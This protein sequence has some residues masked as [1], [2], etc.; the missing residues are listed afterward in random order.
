MWVQPLGWEDPLEEDMATYSSIF[1]FLFQTTISRMDKQRSTVSCEG[2][3]GGSVFKQNP[4]EM[5]ASQETRGSI[6]GSG[7]SSGEGMAMHS[8]VL[9]WRIPW[10]EETAGLQSRG[11]Q[12]ASEDIHTRGVAWG[13]V[14]DIL[15]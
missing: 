9:A 7:R 3:R 13:A 14:S 4:P 15:W 12:K 8:S 11:S 2:F 1:H 5:Q 10:T 6:P